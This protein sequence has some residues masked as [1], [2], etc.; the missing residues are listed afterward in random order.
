MSY[1]SQHD[2]DQAPESK[3]GEIASDIYLAEIAV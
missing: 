1:Y 2:V 3:P